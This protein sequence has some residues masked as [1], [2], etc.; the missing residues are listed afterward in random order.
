[1]K[2]LPIDHQIYEAAHYKFINYML[3]PAHYKFK[4][5]LYNYYNFHYP[6][7]IPFVAR[8]YLHRHNNQWKKLI[9]QTMITAE[10]LLSTYENSPA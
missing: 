2:I 9:P 1:M 10:I 8:V 5:E 7:C 4:R 3:E 6:S